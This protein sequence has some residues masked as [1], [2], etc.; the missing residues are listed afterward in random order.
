MKEKTTI[1]LMQIASQLAA[2]AIQSKAI[3]AS[4]S[5]GRPA[6]VET[7]FEDCLQ[8]VTAHFHD[9]YRAN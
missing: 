7:V 2:S 5:A 9:L 3:T 8:A 1:A 6:Q 4:S